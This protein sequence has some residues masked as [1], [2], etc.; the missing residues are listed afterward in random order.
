MAGSPGGAGLAIAGRRYDPGVSVARLVRLV[1]GSPRAR[2]LALVH[3][4]DDF[5]SSLFTVSLVGSFFVAV[6]FDSSRSRILAYLTLTT[7]PLVVVAPI[8]GRLLDRSR[9]GFRLGIVGTQVARAVLA[10]VAIPYLDSIALYPVVFAVLLMRKAYS[11]AKTALLTS[12]MGDGEELAAAGGSVGRAGVILGSTGTALGGALLA[13]FDPRVVLA[14]SAV[15][16][17]LAAWRAAHLPDPSRARPPMA[18]STMRALPP[19][20]WLSLLG[21]AVLRAVSGAMTYLL[22]LAIKRGGGDEVIYGVALF[23]AGI[24]SF[25]GTYLAPRILRH[26]EAS[27]L[28]AALLLGPAAVAALGVAN[29]TSLPVIVIAATIGLANSLASRTAEQLFSAVP[30]LA[31]GSVVSQGE[32]YFQVASLLG[33]V[34]AVWFTPTPRSGIAIAVVVLTLAGVLYATRLGVRWRTEFTR[35]MVGDQAP[36]T[37]SSLPAALLRES[38][39]LATLGAYRMAAVVGA[40]AAEVVVL[41]TALDEETSRAWA[42]LAIEVERVKRSDAQPDRALVLDI[43]QLVGRMLE[44]PN[45]PAARG[46]DDSW[47]LP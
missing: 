26:V 2:R 41:R 22:A 39:R 44:Q 42:A 13:A 3:G 1:V 18:T 19:R 33:A 14:V 8:M 32:L 23:A 15:G 46:H 6:S 36:A 28:I 29:T 12:T 10:L 4:L 24:G 11:L 25:L 47:L 43:R 5:A 27:R 9:R 30:E 20:L 45:A 7:A 34:A 21:I 35:M 40:S 16:F 38:D 37:D 17:G 31:R